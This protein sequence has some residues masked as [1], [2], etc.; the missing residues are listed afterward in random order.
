MSHIIIRIQRK[1][2]DLEEVIKGLGFEQKTPDRWSYQGRIALNECH[3]DING[4]KEYV[5][6]MFHSIT[7]DRTKAD[8]E[9]ISKILA[10]KY[11]KKRD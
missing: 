3:S 10:D 8:F 2:E 4:E 5:I 1:P 7:D 9:R 6:M 11:E